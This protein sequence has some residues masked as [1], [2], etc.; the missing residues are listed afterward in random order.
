MVSVAQQLTETE[1]RR[2]ET[3]RSQAENEVTMIKIKEGK[4]GPTRIDER[5]FF[6]QH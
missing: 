5:H 1:A 3:K 6:V 2:W 4:T